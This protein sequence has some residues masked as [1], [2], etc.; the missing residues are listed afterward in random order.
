MLK[1]LDNEQEEAAIILFMFSHARRDFAAFNVYSVYEHTAFTVAKMND[2]SLFFV[3]AF[4]LVYVC[5]YVLHAISIFY[6][7]MF[8]NRSTA[9][10][11]SSSSIILSRFFLLASTNV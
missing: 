8:L 11:N 2:E 1:C 4:Y 7:S 10:I 9:T 5:T 6:L 3:C